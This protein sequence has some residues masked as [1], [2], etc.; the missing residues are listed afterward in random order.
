M[1]K[2]SYVV[3]LMYFRS[4]LII[5]I[6]AHKSPSRILL[7]QLMIK[8]FPY[9]FLY[10]FSG[11]H[12]TLCGSGSRQ[13]PHAQR[14]HRYHHRL[15]QRQVGL[16]HPKRGSQFRRHQYLAPYEFK[17]EFSRKFRHVFTTVSA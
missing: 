5:N 3:P 16:R 15:H 6:L 8:N 1:K 4:M 10:F 9:V 17:D 13:F 14:C 2:L 7:Q 12:N 11:Q